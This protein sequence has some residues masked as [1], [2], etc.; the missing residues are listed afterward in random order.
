MR[1]DYAAIELNIE[2]LVLDGF[3]RA[4][5]YVIGAA[6]ERELTRLL[7]E[8]AIPP[9]WHRDVD[10]ARLEGATFQMSAGARPFTIGAQIAGAVYKSIGPEYG[11]AK[12]RL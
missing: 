7:S 2:E 1:D 8:Q 5:R 4:D 11:A 12:E 10:I 3:A 9:G 6:V